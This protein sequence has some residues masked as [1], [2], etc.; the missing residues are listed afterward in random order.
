MD[1]F[2]ELALG[3]KVI[4]IAASVLLIDSFLPWYSV[5]LGFASVSRNGWQS[6]G[7]FY[8]LLAVLLGVVMG[9]QIVVARFTSAS[10]PDK[11]GTL[12]WPRVHMIGGIASLALVVI[13]FLSENEF[14]AFGFYLGILCAAGLCAGGVMLN[15]A[16][17]A[18]APPA[19]PPATDG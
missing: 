3:E 11:L 15:N 6:P 17:G 14:T 2:N 4:L 9:A 1:K 19:S 8:S 7:G 18:G 10:I 12:S 13:K 16:A 5:D